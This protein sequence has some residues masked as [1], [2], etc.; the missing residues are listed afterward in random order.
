MS[1][2][3]IKIETEGK[4]IELKVSPTRLIFNNFVSGL[5]WGVGSVLGAT[6]VVGL[7]IYL[8]GLLNTAPV[9]G[10]YISHILQYINTTR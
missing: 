4:S 10:S 5:A 2:E 8:V 7:L 3:L 9:I 6:V 1:N